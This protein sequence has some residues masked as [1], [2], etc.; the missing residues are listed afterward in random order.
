MNHWPKYLMMYEINAW[1]WL[2]ELSQKAQPAGPK[3]RK[4][5]LD[6]RFPLNNTA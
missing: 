4:S 2:N 3:K 6:A 5:G 1:V